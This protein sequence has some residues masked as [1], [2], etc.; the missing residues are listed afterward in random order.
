MILVK[1]NFI[2]LSHCYS[3]YGTSN[4]AMRLRSLERREKKNCYRRY[5]DKNWFFLLDIFL[6]DVFCYFGG[7]SARIRGSGF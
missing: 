1:I 2:S 4:D 5:Y 7:K 6:R 3:E